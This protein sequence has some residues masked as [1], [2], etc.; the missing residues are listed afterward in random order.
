MIT[1][2]SL[3]S[4]IGGFELGLQMA[5]GFDIRWQVEID[6]WCRRVLAKHWPNV[7]RYS[8]IRSLPLSEMER[9]DLIC[10][11]FPC[12]PASCAGKQ[13]GVEDERWLWDDMCRVCEHFRPEWFLAENVPGLLSND[14]GRLFGGVVRDLASLGYG[15][16]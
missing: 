6:A 16:E 2:G 5:G 10:G 15:V 14:S 3:F 7:R 9:V 4:G 12:Q 13:K 8:D 11:G 1:V